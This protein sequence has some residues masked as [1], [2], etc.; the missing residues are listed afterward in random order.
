MQ[1]VKVAEQ[2]SSTS[3]QAIGT[4]TENADIRVLSLTAVP[5]TAEYYGGRAENADI[6]VLS[7]TAVPGTAEYYGGRV[8]LE[9]EY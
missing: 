4:S 7:L 9:Y 8:V 2:Y 3:T 5:G 6:R 1:S